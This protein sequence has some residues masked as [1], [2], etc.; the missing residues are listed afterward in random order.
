[1]LQMLCSINFRLLVVYRFFV[2]IKSYTNFKQGYILLNC[3]FLAHQMYV[4]LL[5]RW[6]VVYMARF[7]KL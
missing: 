1:M 6:N 7:V 5:I 2:L 4:R 3:Y